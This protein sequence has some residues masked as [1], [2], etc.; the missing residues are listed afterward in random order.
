MNQERINELIKEN[1]INS[2][3]IFLQRQQLE[4]QKQQLNI[5]VIQTEQEMLKLDGELRILEKLLIEEKKN[6][7]LGN[8]NE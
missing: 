5:A 3:R 4:G 2:I 8:K 7:I 6:E 1:Q